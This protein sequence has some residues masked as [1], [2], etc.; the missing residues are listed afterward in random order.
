MN[1]CII[2]W[3]INNKSI[4]IIIYSNRNA[5]LLYCWMFVSRR[6]YRDVHHVIICAIPSRNRHEA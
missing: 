1:K 6:I 2:H 3:F 5:T 4:I